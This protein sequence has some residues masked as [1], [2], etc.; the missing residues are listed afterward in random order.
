MKADAWDVIGSLFWEVGRPSARP[1]EREV[2]EFLDGLPG[3][4]DCA[5]V[6]ASTKEL[7]EALV[8]RGHEVTVLDFS[9]RM[10]EDLEAALSED[11]CRILQLDITKPVPEEMR[12]TQAAV[13]A[14]RL[15][16][17]FDLEEAAAALG[18]MAALL[19]PGGEIRTTVKLGF[20][21]MDLRMFELGRERGCLA[22]F[23]DSRSNTLD[24][25]AAG[26]VLEDAVLPHGDI[27]RDL[28]LQWYR[29]RGVEKRFADSEVKSLPDQLDGFGGQLHLTRADVVPDSPETT[30]YVWQTSDA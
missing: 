29:G 17:R 20:Y 16:N 14:D 2:A 10:C 23:Y 7:V 5:V 18:G 12:G 4:C 8:D 11:A 1:S 22:R 21:P 15:L 26:G 30:R 24:F 6:G 25:N 28:L 27:P 3:S 19:R 13:L 9:R